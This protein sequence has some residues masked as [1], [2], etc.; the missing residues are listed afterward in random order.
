METTYIKREGTNVPFQNLNFQTS[1]KWLYY[2][3]DNIY[4]QRLLNYLNCSIHNAIIESKQNYT[5]GKG[6]IWD[7]NDILL[8][9]FLHNIN[10]EYDANEL[11]LRTAYDLVVFGGFAWQLKWNYDGTRIVSVK[12]QSYANVRLEKPNRYGEYNGYYISSDWRYGRYANNQYKPYQPCFIHKFDKDNR[13][14]N[15]PCLLNYAKYNP[16]IQFY[17]IPDYV[18]IIDY[19]Q[20]DNE[21]A[22]YHLSNVKNGF[23]PSAFLFISGEYT[24]EAKEALELKF[25]QKFQGSSNAG[26]LMIMYS[27]RNEDG[28]ANYPELKPYDTMNNSDFFEYLQNVTTQ[29]IIS[30]HRLNSPTLAGLSGEGGLG[31]NGS[32]IANAVEIFQNT[33]I[34]GYQKP[35]IDKLRMI[36]GINELSQDVA[37]RNEMPITFI[38]TEGTL[39]QIMTTNEMREATGLSPIEGGDAIV[40]SGGGGGFFRETEQLKLNLA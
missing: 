37:F 27:K 4:P 34:K 36:L 11:L 38:F 21:I 10:D 5:A 9:N 14:V 30:G 22:N 40:T 35:I 18:G 24:K 20:I 8:T 31:G 3:I 29:Q 26:E 15:E 28:S 1:Y 2:D 32:E 7:E 19:L 12:H 25:K 6:L 16:M 13:I 33:I 17:A 23:M 39:T